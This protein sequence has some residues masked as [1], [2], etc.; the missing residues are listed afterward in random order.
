MAEI[1]EIY[2][3]IFNSSCQTI[4]N[5]VNCVGVMGKGIA[6]EYK[7]RYPEMYDSYS[8]MCDKHLFKPGLLQ[9]W[10]KSKP[11][12]LNFP[13]KVNWKFPSKLEYIEDGLIKFSSIYIEKNVSSI[14]FPLLGTSAGGLNQDDVLSL[15]SKYLS[16][17][18]NLEIEIYHF[19]PFAEDNLFSDLHQKIY[20]F[21]VDDYK[22]YIGIR[23]NEANN[24][25][26]AL[27]ADTIHSMVALQNI[28]GVGEKTL[29]KIYDFLNNSDKR[30][31]TQKEIQLSLL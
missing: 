29:R 6:L 19:D 30:I 24:I 26:E 31:V 3:N 8:N 27:E 5:T 7:L 14:A 28:K 20:R 9:L 13:T 25:I 12:I 16:P 15:M 23:A 10:T 18:K 17:L 1:K 21:S 2:G 4:V 11:W 22:N